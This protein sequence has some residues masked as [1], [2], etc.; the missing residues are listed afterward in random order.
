MSFSF[1]IPNLIDISELNA[2]IIYNGK[3]CNFNFKQLEN[4]TLS[5]DVNNFI[6]INE[7]DDRNQLN[8]VGAK[9]GLKFI[10]TYESDSNHNVFCTLNENVEFL[11]TYVLWDNKI[12]KE[13]AYEYGNFFVIEN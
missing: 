3:N 5:Y 7:I 2:K 4:L 6:K 11:T 1:K 8:L 10:L 13:I 9:D 12:R